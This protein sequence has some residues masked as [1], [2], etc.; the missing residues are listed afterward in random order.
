MNYK[1]NIIYTPFVLGL[2]AP[3]LGMQRSQGAVIAHFRERRYRWSI[4][5]GASNAD[6]EIKLD[7]DSVTLDLNIN[8]VASPTSCR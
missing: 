3:P 6:M 1:K 8:E 7:V 5:D 4:I 2:L